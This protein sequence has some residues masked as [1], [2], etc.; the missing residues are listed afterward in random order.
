[1]TFENKSSDNMEPAKLKLDFRFADEM[2]GLDIESFVNEAYA[3]E[4]NDPT[5]VLSFRKEGPKITMSEVK[6]LIFQPFG[7]ILLKLVSYC[8][9]VSFPNFHFSPSTHSTNNNR[10]NR[11]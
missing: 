7:Y 3:V 6:Q 5:G 11:T 4:Y 2:D 8:S 9:I 1:M 10:L